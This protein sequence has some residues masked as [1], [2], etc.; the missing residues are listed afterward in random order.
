MTTIEDFGRWATS[1][2]AT[3]H[4]PLGTAS[5]AADCLLELGRLADALHAEERCAANAVLRALHRERAATLWPAPT[6][7]VHEAADDIER[8]VQ[9]SSAALRWCHQ[10]PSVAEICDFLQAARCAERAKTVAVLLPDPARRVVRAL[11][12]Q[13]EL[14]IETE[15]RMVTTTG[16]RHAA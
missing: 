16:A 3:M 11:V 8:A 12:Y 7:R 9:Q 2:L 5:D 1:F 15:L 6:G 14:A 13:V 10:D 4:H